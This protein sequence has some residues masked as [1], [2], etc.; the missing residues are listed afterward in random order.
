[1]TWLLLGHISASVLCSQSQG[2]QHFFQMWPWKWC[3]EAPGECDSAGLCNVLS[4]L[5]QQNS[6][7]TR[8]HCSLGLMRSEENAG[9]WSNQGALPG[10]P[11]SAG[12]GKQGREDGACALVPTMYMWITSRSGG[13]PKCFLVWQ[14]WCSHPISLFPKPD[15]MRRRCFGLAFLFLASP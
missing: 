3:G 5:Q 15:T 4:T 7:F 8:D 13:Q 2:S 12:R 11:C 14:W 10:T 1:M 9:V 6:M